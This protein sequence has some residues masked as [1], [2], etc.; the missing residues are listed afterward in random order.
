MVAQDV[1]TPI[2]WWEEVLVL[3]IWNNEKDL[4]KF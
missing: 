2:W 3:L 1:G 4:V